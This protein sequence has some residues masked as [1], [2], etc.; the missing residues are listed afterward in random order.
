MKPIH[1]LATAALVALLLTTIT[2]PAHAV[3]IDMVTVGN[4][5]NA[6]HTTGYG[7]VNH[8]YRIGKYEVT[9]GQYAEFLNAVAKSD[10]YALWHS[11]M[12]T[13]AVAGISRS[14]SSGAYEYT[15]IGPSGSVQIPQ[16]TTAQRPIASVNWFNA[17]RFANWMHNGQGSGSTETG[18]YTLDG[19][20]T[21]AVPA[22]NQAAQ[23]FIPTLDEWYKA[24]FYKGG[25]TNAGYWQYATQSDSAPGNQPGAGLN[26]ANHR[27]SDNAPAFPF[28]VMPSGIFVQGQNYLTD[29]GAFSSSQSAYG[30]FD[31]N[32][33]VSEWIDRTGP[34]SGDRGCIGGDWN[35]FFS[36][37]QAN[38]LGFTQS[39]DIRSTLTG[40]RLAAPVPE[41]STYCMALA[42]LAC[43]GYSMWRRRKR[44]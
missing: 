27:L 16:A 7:A 28:S 38:H 37:M 12:E 23:F 20:T 26:N 2:A 3:T 1:R 21:G 40:F 14:G 34:N 5:G 41:P 42:G 36:S 33:N 43:G 9:I 18:A 30:T 4:P 24:A 19:A 29:V 8:E 32:G 11:S 35:N 13:S 6:N 25:S 17:A 31:Q 39:A 10:P 15:V 22:R 44:A